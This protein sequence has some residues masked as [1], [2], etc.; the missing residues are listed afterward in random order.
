MPTASGFSTSNANVVVLGSEGDVLPITES[1]GAGFTLIGH[2][3][4]TG[5]VDQDQATAEYDVASTTQTSISVA[6][7]SNSD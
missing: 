1:S 6:F 7:F 2:I 5:G 4:D 3:L